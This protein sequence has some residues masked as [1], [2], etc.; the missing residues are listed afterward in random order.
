MCYRPPAAEVAAFEAAG[1]KTRECPS[2]GAEVPQTAKTCEKCGAK[3]PPMKV[4][5]PTP[6]APGAPG[7][8][9]APKPPAPGK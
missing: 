2:C 4:H 6:P 7:A 1:P 9:G 3:L 5:K 8:P